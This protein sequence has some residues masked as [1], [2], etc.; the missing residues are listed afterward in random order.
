MNK[1]LR[2]RSISVSVSNRMKMK[3]GMRMRMQ[4]ECKNRQRRKMGRVKIGN[5]FSVLRSAFCVL[6]QDR[7]WLLLHVFEKGAT[8]SQPIA[9][10]MD[11]V[12]SMR[13]SRACS[14]YDMVGM[15]TDARSLISAS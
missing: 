10:R 14:P 13:H 7:F 4:H 8:P 9:E 5:D 2:L 1:Y 11:R 12:E 15:L 6:P 3:T